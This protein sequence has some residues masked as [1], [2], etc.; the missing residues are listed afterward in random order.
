M[1]VIIAVRRDRATVH[2][3]KS[4]ISQQRLKIVC[5]L[6]Y[7]LVLIA[8][9][10]LYMSVCIMQWKSVIMPALIFQLYSGYV[11]CCI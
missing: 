7:I 1:M 9:Y 4:A 5:G 2:P 3:L 11:T 6:G 10:R 8:G